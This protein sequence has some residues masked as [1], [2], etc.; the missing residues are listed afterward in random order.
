MEE[1]TMNKSVSKGFM[2]DL[3]ALALVCAE[4]DATEV[5][6]DIKELHVHIEF[7]MNKE[8]EQ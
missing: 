3:L 7:S 1:L 6:F 8:K 5:D 2:R 4:T